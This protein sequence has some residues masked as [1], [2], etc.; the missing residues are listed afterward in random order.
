[1]RSQPRSRFKRN[2]PT[3]PERRIA[4]RVVAH[5]LTGQ[6]EPW[7]EVERF[8]C[9]ASEFR[10]EMRNTAIALSDKRAG[11][12]LAFRVRP[13]VDGVTSFYWYLSPERGPLPVPRGD[14]DVFLAKA[15]PGMDWLSLWAAEDYAVNLFVGIASLGRPTAAKSLR[16]AYGEAVAAVARHPAIVADPG[17]NRAP[18]GALASGQSLYTLPA[19]RRP[20]AR[21]V[22]DLGR[23]ITEVQY[24]SDNDPLDVWRARFAHPVFAAIRKAYVALETNRVDRD[25]DWNDP[26]AQEAAHRVEHELSNWVRDL[27]SL[28][29]L[30]AALNAAP[31][32]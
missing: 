1:M 23:V 14:S 9:D 4:C 7:L 2:T 8:E 3:Q 22:E 10:S 5:P 19:N 28:D 11:D 30:A 20:A 13:Q 27:V 32:R 17:R 6:P 12:V 26:R 15:K 29:V 31:R 18:L 24:C 25:I 16:Q 21:V